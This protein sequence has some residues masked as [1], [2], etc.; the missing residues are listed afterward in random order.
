MGHPAARFAVL[1][2]SAAIGLWVQAVVWLQPVVAP[3]ADLVFA[4]VQEWP[5]QLAEA[6]LAG[7]QHDLAQRLSTDL[8]HSLWIEHGVIA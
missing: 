1:A 6:L 7:V 3:H 2:D 5:A 4:F 8:A